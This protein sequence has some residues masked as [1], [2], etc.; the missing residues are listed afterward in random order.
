MTRGGRV[1]LL[2]E[3]T[4]IEG[5]GGECVADA[6]G[7]HIRVLVRERGEA[8]FGSAQ[9]IESPRFGCGST[10]RAAARA[11]GGRAR[12]RLPG[13]L[14]R[15]PAAARAR[16]HARAARR[17]GAPATLA[18]RRARRHR[19]GHARRPARHRRCCA[20]RPRPS[21]SPGALSILR[22]ALPRGARRR[23]ARELAAAR[24]RPRGQRRA[25]L[26]RRRDPP[27]S[28]PTSRSPAAAGRSPPGRARGARRARRARRATSSRAS[29]RVS[30]GTSP[31]ASAAIATSAPP[32][33]T[34]VAPSA[35]RG[36]PGEDVAERHE[37]E[38]HRPVVRRD[39]RQLVRRDPLRERR[40]PPDVEQRAP[41]RRRAIAG[42]T[43]ASGKPAA[44]SAI[45]AGHSRM[46]AIP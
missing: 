3:D 4:G 8:R 46:N 36:R 25:R 13:R 34:L 12:G 32:S 28:R 44:N 17:F 7:R 40:H 1:G 6:G 23:R 37:P 16:L 20:R 18:D 29:I 35:S 5:D 9:T 2:V 19:G 15:L 43:S 22:S 42:T 26:A 21:C 30:R 27:A 24:A 45:A 14:L 39:A 41:R 38:R 11:P 10:R 31:S 33:R